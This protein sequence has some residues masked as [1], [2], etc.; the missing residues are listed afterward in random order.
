MGIFCP[1]ETAREKIFVL[2]NEKKNKSFIDQAFSAFS[3]K[4]A[5]CKHRV[6]FLE[7]LA[8]LTL[9]LGFQQ[10]NFKKAKKNGVIVTFLELYSKSKVKIKIN[11]IEF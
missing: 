10:I 1:L 4:T 8:I 11:K 5:A 7:H 9:R 2:P 3:V 6:A